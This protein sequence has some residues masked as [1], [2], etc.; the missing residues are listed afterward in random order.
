MNASIP[1]FFLEMSR[2]ARLPQRVLNIYSSPPPPSNS[3]ANQPSPVVSS[4]HSASSH[5]II[6]I[7]LRQAISFMALMTI[8]TSDKQINHTHTLKQMPTHTKHTCRHAHTHAHTQRHNPLNTKMFFFRF[9]TERAVPTG[10]GTGPRG[11]MAFF[12][13]QEQTGSQEPAEH[14]TKAQP[15]A[16]QAITKLISKDSY[17][18]Q[19]ST[20]PDNTQHGSPS[21]G[22]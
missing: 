3:R 22:S 1:C 18:I 7:H 15:R 9:C 16:T 14:V 21:T 8:T 5:N 2:H 20:Q 11:V 4:V 13:E 17:W 6:W 10:S 12:C 19:S